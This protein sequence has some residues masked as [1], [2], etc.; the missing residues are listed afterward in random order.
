MKTLPC[1]YPDCGARRVHHERPDEPRGHQQVEVPD[2]YD[3]ASPVFC[4]L[5]CAMMDGWMTARYETPEQ[6]ETRR[7]AWRKKD[8]ERRAR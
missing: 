6:E 3:E 4:S 5:S 7:A 8:V 2:R 1:K